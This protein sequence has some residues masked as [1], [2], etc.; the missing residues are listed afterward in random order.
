M[1]CI[2]IIINKRETVCVSPWILDIIPSSFVE[3]LTDP[4]DQIEI[5]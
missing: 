5:K 1:K 2:N 3:V 4:L